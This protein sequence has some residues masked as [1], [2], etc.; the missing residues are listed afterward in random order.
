M[1]DLEAP[2]KASLKSRSAKNPVLD[3]MNCQS[4]NKCHLTPYISKPVP[5]LDTVNVDLLVLPSIS[6]SVHRGKW[7]VGQLLVTIAHSKWNNAMRMIQQE[8]TFN[9]CKRVWQTLAKLSL[10]S[11]KQTPS[12]VQELIQVWKVQFFST[13]TKARPSGC[14]KF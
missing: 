10:C 1:W 11:C 8:L 5:A 14:S 3:K 4:F 12:T 13:A 7:W 9:T 6:L 2:C